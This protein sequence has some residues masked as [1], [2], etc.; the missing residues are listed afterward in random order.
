[1]EKQFLNFSTHISS[2]GVTFFKIIWRY[3]RYF[4]CLQQIL[5]SSE[6]L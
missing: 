6:T 4:Q 2:P 5:I 1:M 3:F